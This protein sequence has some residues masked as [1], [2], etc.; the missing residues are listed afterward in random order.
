MAKKKKG[1]C[2]AGWTKKRVKGR[3]GKGTHMQCVPMKGTKV[4][5]KKKKRKG[6]KKKK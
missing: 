1:P 2:K 4:G 6:K 3:K 5:G